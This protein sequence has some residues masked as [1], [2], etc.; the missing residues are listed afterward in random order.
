M[1]SYI[2]D[3]I[4]LLTITQCRIITENAFS[5]SIFIFPAFKRFYF[6]YIWGLLEF[7]LCITFHLNA[8]SDDEDIM[9]EDE[10]KIAVAASFGMSAVFKSPS[11]KTTQTSGSASNKN[12][13]H[14]S[15]VNLK[16]SGPSQQNVDKERLTVDISALKQQYSKLRQRQKQAHIILTCKYIHV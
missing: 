3:F 15:P 16:G 9:D 11:G 2:C 10:E 12:F 6:E 14:S 1:L 5:S 13:P 4:W 7:A 8:C